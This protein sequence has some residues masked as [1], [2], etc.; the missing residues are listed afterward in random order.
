[1]TGG[2]LLKKWIYAIL[3]LLRDPAVQTLLAILA[4]AA[5]WGGFREWITARFTALGKW[6][7]WLVDSNE[8]PN[9]VVIFVI[10]LVIFV[11]LQSLRIIRSQIRV[12]AKP[13]P[14][15]PKITYREV[16][17]VLWSWPVPSG[18]YIGEGPLCPIH[19]LPVEIKKKSAYRSYDDYYE[20]VC[21]GEEGEEGHTIIGP[22][23][24]Q[25]VKRESMGRS[26]PSLFR[27]VNARLK[28][29]DLDK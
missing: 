14:L 17:G 7:P 9:W 8:W 4:I 12:K 6:L 24:N 27:D 18:R 19:K 11:F 10:L 15:A 23:L 2:L 29:M 22:K 20:F 5:A 1:L 26:E 25:L 13:Y 3:K 16:W 21:P 28:V